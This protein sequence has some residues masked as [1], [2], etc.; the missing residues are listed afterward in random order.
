MSIA[1]TATPV[2]P[3]DDEQQLQP[4]VI[5]PSPSD[6]GDAPEGGDASKSS[7]GLSPSTWKPNVEAAEWKPSFGAPAAPSP[8]IVQVDEES[9]GTKGERGEGKQVRLRAYID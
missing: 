2:V 9:K 6:D 7:P 5:A 1:E 4:T 8:A 3:I